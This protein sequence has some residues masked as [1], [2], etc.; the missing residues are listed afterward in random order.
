ME[1]IEDDDDKE[2]EIKWLRAE[3]V[4][5]Q[6]TGFFADHYNEQEEQSKE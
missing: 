5:K 2:W 6:L 4:V 1:D 3:Y